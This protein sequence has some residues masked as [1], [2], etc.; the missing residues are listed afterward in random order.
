MFDPLTTTHPNPSPPV[1]SGVGL[2]RSPGEPF[3][4]N[5]LQSLT[6]RR[7]A[8]LASPSLTAVSSRLVDKTCQ[9]EQIQIINQSI[10]PLHID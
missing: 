1:P 7:P 10:T 4:P 2:T 3:S 5:A 8:L 6:G 9:L